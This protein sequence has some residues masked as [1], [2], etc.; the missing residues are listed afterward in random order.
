MCGGRGSINNSNNSVAAQEESQRRSLFL[1]VS[2]REER[3]RTAAV[4]GVLEESRR[5]LLVEFRREERERTAGTERGVL[6]RRKEE[7]GVSRRL[8]RF[9]E[10][11]ERRW[12]R[13]CIVCKIKIHT[14]KK[15]CTI[16]TKVFTK[17]S[18]GIG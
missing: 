11:R 12:G 1:V 17:F 8:G 10:R 5:S 15:I 18:S 4:R 9:R 7:G 3:R 16:H 6:G 13:V 14:I 2:W